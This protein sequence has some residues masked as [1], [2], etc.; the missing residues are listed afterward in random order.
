MKLLVKFMV[1]MK[2]NNS[3][4]KNLFVLLYKIGAKVLYFLYVKISNYITYFIFLGNGV[5]VKKLHCSGFPIINI[6]MQGSCYIERKLTL[7][8]GARN[9]V[10]GGNR[11]C[12]LIVRN[13]GILRIGENVGMN[14][15]TIYVTTSITIG[16]NVKIGGG[17]MIFDT[18]FHST[19]YK[20]RLLPNDFKQAFNKP[21]II[22]DDVFIGTS[23]IICKGVRIGARSIIVAGS[24][25]V[26]DVPEDEC[27]GGNPA[28]FIKKLN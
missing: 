11:P 7:N 23:C 13:N 17:C 22:E 16:N 3:I 18:D 28:H 10:T 4:F 21:V 25:V 15:S 19:D 2:N 8:N 20:V 14:C 12:K 27:W 24:V 9:S 1:K 26:K 6:S 5:N